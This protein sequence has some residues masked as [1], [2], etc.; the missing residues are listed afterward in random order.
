MDNRLRD[1]SQRVTFGRHLVF[2]HTIA[3]QLVIDNAHN[4]CELYSTVN[5]HTTRELADSQS[6]TSDSDEMSR[7]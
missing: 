1:A 3:D 5:K 4:N 6:R 7:E 2:S